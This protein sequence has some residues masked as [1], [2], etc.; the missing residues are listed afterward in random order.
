MP[1]I[2]SC[3]PQMI[4]ALEKAGWKVTHQPFPV[5]LSRV[6]GIIA[7]ARLRHKT[8]KRQIIVLEIKCF[9]E[10]RPALDEF[11]RATGQYLVYRNTLKLKAIKTP[12]YLAVPLTAYNTFFSRKSI[13]ATLND[14][15]IKLVVVDIEKEEVVKWV[16]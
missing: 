12:V 14:A 2:D 10:N 4:R 7:D 3:E 1:A 16:D 13:Q 5:R 9:P 15:K 6:E 8:R 11:Y